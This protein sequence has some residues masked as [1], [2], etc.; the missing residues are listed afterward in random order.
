MIVE[1]L[2][3]W[4][5]SSRAAPGSM[6]TGAAEAGEE[7]ADSLGRQRT[8]RGVRVAKLEEMRKHAPEVVK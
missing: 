3:A 8:P 1:E 5:K 6:E 4:T 2:R 7:V